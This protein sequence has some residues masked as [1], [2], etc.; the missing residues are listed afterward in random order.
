MHGYDFRNAPGWG[1]GGASEYKDVL[2]AARYLQARPEFKTKSLGIYGLSWGGYLT[3]QALARNSDVFKAGFDMAGV[4]DFVGDGFKNSPAAY[5]DGWRSPVYLAQGDDDRNA[6]FNQGMMLAQSV[7]TE[8][9][10]VELVERVIPNE[11][12]ELA[13]K[14]EDMV[15]VYGGGSDFLLTRLNSSPAGSDKGDPVRV[16][17]R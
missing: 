10:Q 15:S 5:L 13:L 1:S 9:P 3:E 14:F 7:R 2:G 12:H 16:L 11:T 4:F 17:S 6:D 8:R